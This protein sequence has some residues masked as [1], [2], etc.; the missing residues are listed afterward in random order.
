MR[1]E[2]GDFGWRKVKVNGLHLLW[3]DVKSVEGRKEEKVKEI[4]AKG[5]LAIGGRVKEWSPR[6]REDWVQSWRTA[7]VSEQAKEKR[8][9]VRD[10]KESRE[11][12][13]KESF[14]CLS[15]ISKY[16]NLCLI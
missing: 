3:F 11:W 8:K 6:E 15:C 1:A 10:K 4:K 7:W 2:E 13:E 14:L 9:I 16:C 5:H 12:K